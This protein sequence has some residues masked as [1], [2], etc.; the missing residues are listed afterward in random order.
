MI[1]AAMCSVAAA[2]DDDPDDGIDG[3]AETDAGTGGE[4]AAAGDAGSGEDAGAVDAGPIEPSIEAAEQT[5]GLSTVVTI[6]EVNATDTVWIVIH[7]DDGGAPGEIIGMTLVE[8]GSHPDVDVE[9]DRPVA[10]D[11][12]LHAMLHIDA[13]PLETFDDADTPVLVD[14]AP[15]SASFVVTVEAGTPAVRLTVTAGGNTGYDFTSAEP[16]RYA[17]TIGEEDEDQTLTLRRG[18]RYELVNEVSAAH[19]FQFIRNTP[20]STPDVV[21][22][23]EGGIAGM[24]EGDEDIA[25]SDEDSTL[26][27]TVS[28]AFESGIDGYRCE[29]HP[30]MM[31]GAV[32]VIAP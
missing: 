28:S 20:G 1:A 26:R 27:F 7:E 17:D 16:A 5:L 9:L 12:T 21:Q 32:A 2:C 31:R 18:W 29:L 8:S 10:S 24:L 14:G 30:Q 15:V 22:L 25:F 3:G 4:D 13:A 6:A 19:P 23:A 11:E